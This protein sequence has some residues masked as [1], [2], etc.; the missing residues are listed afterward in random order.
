ME[1]YFSLIVW[2]FG[3]Q[4][5]EVLWSSSNHGERLDVWGTQCI[6]F[7]AKIRQGCGGFLRRHGWKFDPVQTLHLMWRP[8]SRWTN[9]VLKLNFWRFR[10]YKVDWSKFE[11]HQKHSNFTVCQ[12]ISRKCLINFPHLTQA[13]PCLKMLSPCC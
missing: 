2:G 7:S 6:A 4:N 5:S 10:F 12:K 13:S 1:T 8:R 9:F 3:G 11:H